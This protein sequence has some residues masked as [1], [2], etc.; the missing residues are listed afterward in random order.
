MSQDVPSKQEHVY[1]SFHPSSSNVSSSILS[2]MAHAEYNVLSV[3]LC[4]L[5]EPLVLVLT[6]KLFFFVGSSNVDLSF[7][8]GF[9]NFLI[10]PFQFW[11]SF[12]KLKNLLPWFKNDVWFHVHIHQDWILY[13]YRVLQQ[14]E[15]EID[16]ISTEFYNKLKLRLIV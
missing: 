3:G 13:K 1:N 5:R 9:A 15:I 11:H 7:E 4:F 12:S 10:L 16:C 14:I 8:L 6:L 2:I